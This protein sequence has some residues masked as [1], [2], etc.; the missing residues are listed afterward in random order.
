MTHLSI[1]ELAFRDYV[2]AMQWFI[3][4]FGLKVVLE[5]HE[6]QY[7]LLDAG[8]VKLAI[9]GDSQAQPTRQVLLQWE[10]DDVEVWHE[11]SGLKL[12]K[13]MKFSSEGYRRI[14]VEGVEGQ[15]CL[16]YDWKEPNL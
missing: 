13:P 6:E 5:S 9:K 7:V 15:T 3:H 16:I 4:N 8:S 2:A 1:I 11:R 10:V 12:I 14:I